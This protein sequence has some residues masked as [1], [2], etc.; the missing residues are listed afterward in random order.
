MAL[1]PSKSA[2]RCAWPLDA[3]THA[4]EDGC[5]PQNWCGPSDHLSY[6]SYCW[7]AGDALKGMLT[8]HEGG[9][10]NLGCGQAECSYNE[11]IIDG[12]HWRAHLPEIVEAFFQPE[13]GGEDSGCDDANACALSVRAV[14]AAFLSAFGIDADAVP[15]VSY[16]ARRAEAL[17]GGPFKLIS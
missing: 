1:F 5:P 14:R 12:D 4:M 13:G 9:A 2:V 17:A 3:G 11:V 10:I 16:E 6:H 8:A 7:H 15:L